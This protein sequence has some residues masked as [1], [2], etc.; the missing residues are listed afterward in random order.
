MCEYGPEDMEIVTIENYEKRIPVAKDN[1]RRAGRESQITL[2]EGDAG[3][4][5]KNL[6]GTFDMI[7]MDAAKGQYIHWLPDVLRL[8]KRE[9]CWYLTTCCRKGILLNLII[10]WNGV[11]VQSIKE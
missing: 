6:T 2:L 1:F 8:M 5:L 10:L 9:A 4:I 11:T 3:E 7:F